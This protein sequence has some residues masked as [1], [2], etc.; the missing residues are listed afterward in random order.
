MVNFLGESFIADVKRANSGGFG[1]SVST[2]LKQMVRSR[3][4]VAALVVS[5][6]RKD[7]L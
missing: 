7:A 5:T 3:S 2:D 1:P 4:N 6:A